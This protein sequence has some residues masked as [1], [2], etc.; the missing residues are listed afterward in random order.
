ML[1][2]G[3]KRREGGREKGGKKKGRTLLL[4]HSNGP[5]QTNKVEE[6]GRKRKRER[7]SSSF[8]RSPL[9]ALLPVPWKEKGG[10]GKKGGGRNSAI[11]STTNPMPAVTPRRQIGEIEREKKEKR[12]EGKKKRKA[13]EER[14]A[15]ILSIR[16]RPK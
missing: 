15:P 1:S 2:F 14:S 4:P 8:L 9:P 3:R 10:R 16:C 5:V 11:I 13:G 7:R 12:K 6:K